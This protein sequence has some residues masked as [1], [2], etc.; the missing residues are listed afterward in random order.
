MAQAADTAIGATGFEPAAFWSQ[1]RRST[2]LSYAPE[3]RFFSQE[4]CPSQRY[5]RK[6]DRWGLALFAFKFIR[7]LA[8]H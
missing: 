6:A 4:H 5:K 2:K 3:S 1:T 8:T 7:I